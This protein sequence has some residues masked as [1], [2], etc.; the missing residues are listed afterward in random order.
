MK[1][2]KQGYRNAADQPRDH[3]HDDWIH[4]VPRYQLSPVS[5][6]LYAIRNQ[7]VGF[8]KII[9]LRLRTLLSRWLTFTL[10]KCPLPSWSAGSGLT[11][12]R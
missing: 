8:G 2:H 9:V 3:N 6:Q 10:I 11:A 7:L 1:R 5:R 4:D 12:S